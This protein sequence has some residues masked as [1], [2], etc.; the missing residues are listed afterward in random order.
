LF[1]KK[2]KVSKFKSQN[3]WHNRFVQ[4]KNNLKSKL[5]IFDSAIRE[6]QSNFYMNYRHF[7]MID[8]QLLYTTSSITSSLDNSNLNSLPFELGE[9]RQLIS[10]QIEENKKKL[11]DSYLKESS[12]YLYNNKDMLESLE[13]CKNEVNE[14]N[15]FYYKL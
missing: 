11:R 9:F 10:R 14:I 4:S 13:T 12:D 15:S 7:R 8:I 1:K 6:I 5:F 2:E 3:S